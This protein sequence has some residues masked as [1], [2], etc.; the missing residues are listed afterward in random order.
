MEAKLAIAAATLGLAL[1]VTGCDRDETND[2]MGTDATGTTYPATGTPGT[3]D[4]ATGAAPPP[5]TMDDTTGTAPGTT[6]A[7]G[8]STSSGSEQPTYPNGIPPAN[9]DEDMT[10]GTTEPDTGANPGG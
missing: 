7:T 3:T 2:G 5:G 4:P 10:P 9:P 1:A 8:G 6:D